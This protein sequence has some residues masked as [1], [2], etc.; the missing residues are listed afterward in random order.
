M[1]G[2]I[3]LSLITGTAFGLSIAKYF[4]EDEVI[5]GGE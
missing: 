4:P 3:I 2:Y 5:E 1:I